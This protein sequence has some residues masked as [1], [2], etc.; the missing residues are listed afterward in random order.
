VIRSMT[1]FARREHRDDDVGTLTCELR[2]VN[3]RYLDLSFRLPEELRGSENAL[4]EKSTQRLQRGRLECQ[5][6]YQPGDTMTS[7]LSINEALAKAL[8]EAARRIESDMSNPA[9]MTAIDLLRWPGIVREPEQDL[10][11]LTAKALALFETA[12]KDLIESREREGTRIAEFI[13]ARCATITEIVARVRQR[14][15]E[16]LSAIR[17][18][19]M[20]RLAEVNV[21]AEPNRLEQELAYIAQ[22]LDI[23]EELDRLDGHLQEV[24][25]TLARDEPAGRRLDFLMQEFNREANTISSKSADLTTTQ[26]AVDLKVLI[27]QMREQVQNIE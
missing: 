4:R 7:S 11:P 20:A 1:A 13:K 21:Q 14:R 25:A 8:I 27:E 23:E 18:K 5:L 2:S 15:P 22:R 24:E 9:R 10:G 19:L 12:I 6:R 17:D 16:V 3:H 26:A